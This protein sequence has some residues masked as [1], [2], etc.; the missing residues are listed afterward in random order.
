MR[1]ELPDTFDGLF[2][3]VFLAVFCF[4]AYRLIRYGGF[5]GALF[6]HE[7]DRTLGEVRL[8]NTRH[9]KS[10]I[11]VHRLRSTSPRK[12]VGLELHHRNFGEYRYA[13]LHLSSDE[14]LALATLLREA[15]GERA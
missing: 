10:T 15:V 3:L 5:S 2:L 12:W 6:A 13:P 9:S 1:I 7:I 11:T 8:I 14:A 4:V